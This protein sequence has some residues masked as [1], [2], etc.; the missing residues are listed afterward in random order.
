MP[1]GPR[2]VWFEV[3]QQPVIELKKK[4]GAGLQGDGTMGGVGQ[5]IWP[6]VLSMSHVFCPS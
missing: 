3:D 6:P 2:I 4:V 5:T 1:G